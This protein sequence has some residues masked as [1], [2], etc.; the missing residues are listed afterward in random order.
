[1]N[2]ELKSSYVTIIYS[3]IFITSLYVNSKYLLNTSYNKIIK[4]DSVCYF[5]E[6]NKKEFEN[7]IAHENFLL[8]YAPKFA[9]YEFVQKLCENK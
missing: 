6:L 2:S 9:V 4:D 8:Y 3:I 5:K 7:M 1:V